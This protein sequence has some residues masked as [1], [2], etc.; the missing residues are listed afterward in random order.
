MSTR[1]RLR[2]YNHTDGS[3]R[4]FEPSKVEVGPD[5]SLSLTLIEQTGERRLDAKGGQMMDEY[6]VTLLAIIGPDG[7][8]RAETVDVDE[9]LARFG[10]LSALDS[11]NGPGSR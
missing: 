4:D 1:T 10:G 7:R 9:Q 5:G 6:R 8:L 2:C 3:Y 11:R